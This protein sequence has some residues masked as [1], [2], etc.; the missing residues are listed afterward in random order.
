MPHT[1]PPEETLRLG[2]KKP[3]DDDDAWGDPF[4]ETMDILD[5][6]PGVFHCTSTTRPAG[7]AGQVIFEEDTNRFQTFILGQWLP[8]AGATVFIQPTNPV[9][10]GLIP[11]GFPFL[12][13]ETGLGVGGSDFSV[14]FEDGTP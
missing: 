1:P 6:S 13:I 14:W 5:N 8:L 2:L 9:I 11:A 12:W 3:F 10:V 7:Y 4:R